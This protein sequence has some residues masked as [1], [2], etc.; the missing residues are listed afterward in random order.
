MGSES[1]IQFLK[2]VVSIRLLRA[3]LVVGALMISNFRVLHHELLRRFRSPRTKHCVPHRVPGLRF[4]AVLSAWTYGQYR[5][6]KL[7]SRPLL[8]AHPPLRQLFNA[9]PTPTRPTFYPTLTHYKVS[10]QACLARKK[11]LSQIPRHHPHI[12]FHSTISP[13]LTSASSVLVRLQPPT[14]TAFS[15]ISTEPGS[16]GR[17]GPG[18]FG[19]WCRNGIVQACS[20][21]GL[22][23]GHPGLLN[24]A[25]MRHTGEKGELESLRAG[26][27]VGRAREHSAAAPE[28]SDFGCA[29][30]RRRTTTGRADLCTGEENITIVGFDAGILGVLA[31]YVDPTTMWVC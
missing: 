28:A 2:I 12:A 22:P 8:L 6:E 11:V 31:S 16:R 15:Q 3:S 19:C 9:H 1:L 17:G 13:D 4:Q 18:G 20:G 14:A 26:C 29:Q 10:K 5:C 23:R 24:E 25:G 27:P 21:L 30:C 7:A